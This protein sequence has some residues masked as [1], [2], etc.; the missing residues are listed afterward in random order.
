MTG[1]TPARLI[2][3]QWLKRRQNDGVLPLSADSE[4]RTGLL[5]RPDG[6]GRPSHKSPLK[7][8]GTMSGHSHWATIKHKKGAIDAKRGK[9]WS[10]LSRAIIIAAKN[11][12]GDPG[13]ESQA[14]LRHRQGPRSLH[15]QGQYRAG[16]QTRHRR[17]GRPGFRGN[18]LRGLRPR[19]RA[20]FSSMCS[21]T[22]AIARPARSARSS[23]AAAAKWARPAT[24]P[25]SSNAR[26]SSPWT[27]SAT[28]EDTLMGIVLDAG[29]DDLK[30][31]GDSFE[32]TCDPAVFNQVKQAL[33]K[34][35]IPSPT[36]KSPRFPR[37]RARTSTRKSAR[38]SCA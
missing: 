29:A 28:D 19:R 12:G 37:T 6:L 20:P 13:H 30:K 15:A 5:A 34:A 14:P 7:S 35:E 22:T 32:I 24:S 1:E 9:L 10:K 18:H 16:H 11:G 38:R 2:K 36:P 8:G 25:F 26:A 3:N 21:P 17:H 27:A 4:N 31:H 23:S 33:E